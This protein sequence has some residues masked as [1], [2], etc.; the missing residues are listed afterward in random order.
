MLRTITR[1]I[2]GVVKVAAELLAPLASPP[3]SAALHQPFWPWADLTDTNRSVGPGRSDLGPAAGYFGPATLAA[4]TLL[5]RVVGVRPFPPS[6]L[7]VR[8][9]QV[10]AVAARPFESRGSQAV[11]AEAIAVGPGSR[12]FWPL[13]SE[14][15]VRA[16]ALAVDVVR[17]QLAVGAASLLRGVVVSSWACAQARRSRSARRAVLRGSHSM[18]AVCLFLR[19]VRY[20]LRG[21]AQIVLQR[22][23]CFGDERLTCRCRVRANARSPSRFAGALRVKSGLRDVPARPCRQNCSRLAAPSSL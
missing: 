19:F 1:R 11:R 21:A 9:V 3:L 13:K 2:D 10:Q 4:L 14:L 16:E 22:F 8:I 7:R 15:A 18:C 5:I 6:T 17:V 23:H 20:S 12:P